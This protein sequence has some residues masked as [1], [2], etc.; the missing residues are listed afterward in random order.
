VGRAT[1]REDRGVLSAEGGSRSVCLWTCSPQS[2]VPSHRDRV[3]ALP[4]RRGCSSSLSARSNGRS[5]PRL[6]SQ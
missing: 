3:P 2:R 1:G 5:R 6:T 4:T